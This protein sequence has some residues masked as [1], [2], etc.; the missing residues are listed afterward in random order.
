MIPETFSTVNRLTHI[1]KLVCNVAEFLMINNE[2]IWKILKY[3]TSDA[4]KQPDLSL[5][6]KKD[7]TYKANKKEDDCRLFLQLYPNNLTT[8][9]QSRI[10]IDIANVIPDNN[11]VSTVTLSIETISHNS[12]KMLDDTNENRDVVLLQNIVSTLNGHNIQGVTNFFFNRDYG[13]AI[14]NVRYD[15]KAYSGFNILMSC[16]IS[17]LSR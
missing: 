4:L 3:S 9:M 1:R 10:Y 17:D 2:E 16:K 5:K 7:L 6:E 14:R 13:N 8:Q 11:Q 12:M 15:T